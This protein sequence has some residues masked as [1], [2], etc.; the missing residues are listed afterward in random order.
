MSMYPRFG[1]T[2]FI[3]KSNSGTDEGRVTSVPLMGSIVSSDSVDSSEY[4][5]L[6][7]D[8]KI[9]STMMGLRAVPVLKHDENS[10]DPLFIVGCIG[11]ANLVFENILI[12]SPTQVLNVYDDSYSSFGIKFVNCIIKANTTIFISRI[13]SLSSFFISVKNRFIQHYPPTK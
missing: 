13:F 11:S 6:Y 12:V 3:L 5:R 10:T 4:A 7:G 9:G 1:N 8:V 2:T